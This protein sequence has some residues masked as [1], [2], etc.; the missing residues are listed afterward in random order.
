MK[1]LCV[2]ERRRVNYSLQEDFKANGKKAT[3]KGMRLSDVAGLQNPQYLKRSSGRRQFE[4]NK[5]YSDIEGRIVG[6][7]G[8]LFIRGELRK[9]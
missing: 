7:V 5:S 3:N 4:T 6:G 2:R 9:I 8:F 1:V